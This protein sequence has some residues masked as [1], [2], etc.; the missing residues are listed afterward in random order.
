MPD[1]FQIFKGFVLCMVIV[2]LLYCWLILL[3]FFP[4]NDTNVP[5]RMRISKAI[6]YGA[7]WEREWGPAVTRVVVD[8]HLTYEELIQSFK[9]TSL[10]S[11]I[12]LVNELYLPDCLNYG[13]ICN[14]EQKHY[15]VAGYAPTGTA[16]PLVSPDLVA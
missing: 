15:Q 14:P 6:Q 5:R 8:L 4:N 11:H 13:I 7:V 2:R 10:P 12:K 1:E 16:E 3:V 9:V